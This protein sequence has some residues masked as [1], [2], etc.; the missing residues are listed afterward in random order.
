MRVVGAGLSMTVC[1]GLFAY[2]GHLLD[3]FL[4]LSPWCLIVGTLAG[5]AVSFFHLVSTYAPEVL[6]WTAKKSS[7]PRKRK[8][9]GTSVESRPEESSDHES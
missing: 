3:E 2:G 4:G 8:P 5:A 9:T 6:P 7:A 1:I